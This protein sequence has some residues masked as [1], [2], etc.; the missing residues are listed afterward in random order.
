MSLYPK[1]NIEVGGPLLPNRW[2]HIDVGGMIGDK[3]PTA[4]PIVLRKSVDPSPGRWYVERREPPPQA[5]K[6]HSMPHTEETLAESSSNPPSTT[7][8]Y[9]V[10]HTEEVSPESSSN[11]PSTTCESSNSPED[12]TVVQ[13]TSSA[14]RKMPANRRYKTSTQAKQFLDSAVALSTKQVAERDGVTTTTVRQR[15]V[16]AAKTIAEQDGRVFGEVIGE[17]DARRLRNGVALNTRS[18][19][20]LSKRRE[21]SRMRAVRKEGEKLSHQEPP[22]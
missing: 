17:F 7:D 20:Y 9:S 12:T 15:V 3:Y 19:D 10:S 21:G 18:L 1:L 14:F 2:N 8:D 13:T 22:T 16:K 11:L 6:Y 5:T 4:A